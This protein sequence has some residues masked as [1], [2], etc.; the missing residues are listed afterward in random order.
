MAQVLFC[1]GANRNIGL[2]LDPPV[3]WIEE[4][5]QIRSVQGLGVELSAPP[6]EGLESAVRL[7]ARFLAGQSR[8]EEGFGEHQPVAGDAHGLSQA[9][10]G[11]LEVVGDMA[12]YDHRYR[13]I[14]EGQSF[15]AG[16]DHRDARIQQ[17]R[18]LLKADSRHAA[19]GQV[20]EQGPLAAAHVEDLQ[21][22]PGAWQV[23]ADSVRDTLDEGRV[24]GV[25]PA[26]Q[27]RRRGRA[28]HRSPLCLYAILQAMIR[29]RSVLIALGCAWLL[30]GCAAFEFKSQELRVRHDAEQDTLEFTLLY[31]DV[32][33]SRSS[34]DSTLL[35]SMNVEEQPDRESSVDVVQAIASGRRYFVVYDWPLVFDL[36]GA[37]ADYP[38]DDPTL[39]S[40]PQAAM[41]I[42]G[43]VQ[44]RKAQLFV[45]E[46]GKLG[47]FQ[48]VSLVEAR[49][50]IDVLNGAVNEFLTSDSED[51]QALDDD[52]DLLS[53]ETLERWIERARQGQPWV[54]LANGGFEL[55]V[56]LSAEE[57]ARFIEGL[58]RESAQENKVAAGFFVPLAKA[59]T[60]L[61][62]Q[63]GVLIARFLP[64]D[65]GWLSFQFERKQRASDGELLE[66]LRERKVPI[67][68]MSVQAARTLVHGG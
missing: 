18:R 27:D 6:V 54:V 57:L 25:H 20:G 34:S 45:D 65:D 66:G 43:G 1:P 30:A 21:F 19:P 17:R 37:E 24:G 59:L 47:M 39:G 9:A 36:D 62:H 51:V 26:P 13:S 56:P 12:Q 46:E 58:V 50:R 55:R 3:L 7:T 40:L 38:I 23:P 67:P 52:P 44:V 29:F 64:G 61:T 63:D 11:V 33:A 10:P 2:H 14:R 41:D 15:G 49:R 48:V 22:V 28:A 31:L 68:N 42:V 60:S 16:R 32:E 5:E 53:P 35:D 4:G 8:L